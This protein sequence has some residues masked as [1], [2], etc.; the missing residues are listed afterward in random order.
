MPFASDLSA[1]GGAASSTKWNP[2]CP[3]SRDQGLD[4]IDQH[5]G[6]RQVVARDV[7]EVHVAEAALLPVAAVRDGQL[8]P[9]AVRP[10]AVHRVEHVEQRQVVV[11]RQAGV[12]GRAAFGERDVGLLVKST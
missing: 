4:S 11:Q 7:V 2:V 3:V 5:V 1:L 6:G 12:G 10:Q 8:V 9:A